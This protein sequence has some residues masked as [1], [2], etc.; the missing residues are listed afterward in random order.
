M[1]DHQSSVSVSSQE[2]RR[3]SRARLNLHVRFLL[4]DGSE[5]AGIVDDISIGGMNIVS[6][7]AAEDGSVIIAYVED[8]GR[9]EGVVARVDDRGIAVRLVLS[10]LRREKLQERLGAGLGIP[11]PAKGIEGRRF[12][13]ETTKGA[14]IVRRADG[15]ELAARVTDLS[16]GGVAVE[17]AEWPPLGEQVM[18]GKMRGRVVRHNENGFAIEFSEMPPSRGSLS[19]QLSV[20]S[21]QAA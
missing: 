17:A 13:R 16:L 4:Q 9:L 10:P 19:E 5:N 1:Y 7:V 15:T 8:L 14:A 6:N 18:V 21:E 2:R 12:E 20:S 3:Q 11:A